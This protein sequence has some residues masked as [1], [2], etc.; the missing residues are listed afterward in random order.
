MPGGRV[1]R[2]TL[3]STRVPRTNSPLPFHTVDRGRLWRWSDVSEWLGE[4]DAEHR[5]SAQL[6][7]A[8][9]AALELRYHSAEMKDDTA[10]K[11]LLAMVNP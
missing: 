7:A 9:N 2:L 8:T 5:E 6:I 10:V 3:R 4:F 1:C 11:E